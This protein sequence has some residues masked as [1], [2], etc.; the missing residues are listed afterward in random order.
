MS[1]QRTAQIF[2]VDDYD[3]DAFA[4]VAS[5]FGQD[6]FGYVVTP[7]ADHLIRWHQDVAFRGIYADAAYILLD[8]RFLALL[9]RATNGNRASVC[10]GS[11]LAER[12]LSRVILPQDRV[13]LIGA[14]Q[15]QVRDLE[16]RYG[17]RNLQHFNPPQGFADDPK[18]VEECLAFI[19]CQ[20]PFRFCLLAV[21]TPRQEMLAQ[22]LRARG[23]AR[24]L[25][26]CVGAAINFLTGKERRAPLWIRRLGF[27]WLFRLIRQPTRLAHRYLVRGP[28]VFALIPYTHLTMRPPA[29]PCVR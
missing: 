21:G 29:A 19:E 10:P 11:D 22:A 8:S 27:E 20:S 18:A 26:L 28:R 15:S 14:E 12:L 6:K 23:V 13:V 16:T 4:Q 24:G 3:L 5:R 7:N 17:L 9:F 25:V 1:P 2:P